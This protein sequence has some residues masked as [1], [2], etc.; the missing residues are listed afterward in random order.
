[1]SEMESKMGYISM[2]SGIA[3][4][5]GFIGT[6]LGVIL[7]FYNISQTRG[8]FDRYDFCRSVSK[9]DFYPRPDWWSVGLPLWDT[10]TC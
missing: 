8:Y 10:I 7:I 9:D 3:P 6:I 1:M 4:R 5:L 2:V